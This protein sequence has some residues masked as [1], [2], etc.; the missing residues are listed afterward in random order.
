MQYPSYKIIKDSVPQFQ[1]NCGNCSRL[2]NPVLDQT[3][4]ETVCDNCGQP[5][6]IN[7]YPALLKDDSTDHVSSIPVLSDE[8]SCFYHPSRKAV[9]PCSQCGRFLCGLCDIELNGIHRCANCID[10][11]VKE[12]SIE[13]L[14]TNR[15][16]YDYIALLL[17]VVP[18]IFIYFTLITAP[19]S[20]YIAIR[21]WK[22][23]GSLVARWRW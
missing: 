15:T 12:E 1:V 16:R 4:L 14:I 8:S 6:T 18:I 20:L 17:A 5:T 22:A 3:H 7:L 19:V 9:I 2:I 11:A 10:H 23:P 21:Y 13:N